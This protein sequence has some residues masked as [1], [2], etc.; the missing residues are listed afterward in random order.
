MMME[1]K[2]A[3]VKQLLDVLKTQK[4]PE[5]AKRYK[6]HLEIPF[7]IKKICNNFMK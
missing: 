2:A 3:A 6:R 5:S 4:E 1:E 7:L